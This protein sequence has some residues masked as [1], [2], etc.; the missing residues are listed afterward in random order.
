M[1]GKELSKR[2][3]MKVG[4]KSSPKF[5]K[6]SLIRRARGFYNCIWMTID[7]LMQVLKGHHNIINR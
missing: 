1:K 4:L 5:L 6:L 2:F 3:R 7:F